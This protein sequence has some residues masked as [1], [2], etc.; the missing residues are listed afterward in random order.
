MQL[1][2]Y[3]KTGKLRFFISAIMQLSFKQIMN[4]F[5][6]I[7]SFISVAFGFVITSEILGIVSLSNTPHVHK[8]NNW[9][10]RTRG[11]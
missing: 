10:N 1:S 5:V 6:F 4:F 11:K 2:G 9:I 3:Y 8:S 7:I